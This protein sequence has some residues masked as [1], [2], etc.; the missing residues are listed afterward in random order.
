MSGILTRVL[1]KQGGVERTSG[2]S[3][4]GGTECAAHGPADP[5]A[6]M[7]T[8]RIPV[9]RRQTVM[10]G[11][12]TTHTDLR[13]RGSDGRLNF[14]GSLTGRAATDPAMAGRGVQ[15]FS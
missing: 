3:L 4:R 12:M 15:D 2:L 8:L 5:P 11:R 1:V 10:V 6:G 14:L 9:Y 7:L 13:R